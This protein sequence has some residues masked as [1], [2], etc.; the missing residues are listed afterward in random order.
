MACQNLLFEKSE[1]IGTVTINRPQS[2]NA[3]NSETYRELYRLFQEIEADPEV[4][5]VILTGSGDKAFAAGTDISA[6]VSLSTAEAHT[7][8]G[9]LR[10]ACDLIYDFKKPVIAAIHGFALGGGCELAVC[11]DF[12]VASET[13]RFGQPEINLA[14]IPGSSGTQRLPRLIGI[15][16]AK[17]LIYF[18]NMIDASTALSWGLV[19]KV[20]SA[21]GLMPEAREMANKLLSKSRPV[22]A[23][24]KKAINAGANVDLAS[25][26]EIEEQCFAEC[27]STE[28]QK[29]GMRAFLA[30]RRPNL[31]NK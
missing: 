31:K 8:V 28:D 15:A 29:E 13:A 5:V 9:D 7:F 16:R 4:G 21:A 27:F 24:A 25:A 23:L 22:L 14:I 3:L 1:G 26:L 30:K 11:A 6:M 20:V 19:N 12:R 18:G 10:R 17:E 2:L